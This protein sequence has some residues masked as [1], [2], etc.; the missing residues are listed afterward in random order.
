MKDGFLAAW[1][2]FQKNSEKN[3]PAGNDDC[4]IHVSKS[5]AIK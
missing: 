1:I 3:A 4:L 2:P 5:T